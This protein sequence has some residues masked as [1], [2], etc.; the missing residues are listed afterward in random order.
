MSGRAAE[1][2]PRPLGMAAALLV[3]VEDFIVA[4]YFG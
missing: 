3:K 2:D 1:T 4:D